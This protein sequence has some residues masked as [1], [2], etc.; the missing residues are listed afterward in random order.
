MKTIKKIIKF[1]DFLEQE[2]IK[3]MMHSGWGKF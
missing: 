2:R 1:L 3:C